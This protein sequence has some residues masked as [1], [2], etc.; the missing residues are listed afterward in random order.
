MHAVPFIDAHNL[1]Y[2]YCKDINLTIRIFLEGGGGGR[3]KHRCPLIPFVGKKLRA[4]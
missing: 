1:R 4:K 3:D 2:F